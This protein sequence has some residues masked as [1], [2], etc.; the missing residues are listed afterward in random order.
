MRRLIVNADDFGLTTGI[1][2][3][4][5]QTHASGVVTSTTLMANGP[6]CDDAVRSAKNHPRLSVGCHIVLV[7]GIP[8]LKASDVRT[9]VE[10]RDADPPCFRKSPGSF[11]F[12]ALAG[13]LD[14]QQIEAE[15]TAQIRMLQG[16]GIVVTHLDTHKHTH[17]FPAVLRPLLRAAKACGIDALRNPFGPRLPFSVR[18]LRLRPRLW[19]RYFEVRVLSGFSSSFR[20]MVRE[21][22]MR[23]PDGT[24]G[25]AATGALDLELFGRIVD[26]IPEGTWEFVCHPGYHD[27]DLARVRT[28]LRESREKELEILTSAEARERLQRRGIQLIAYREL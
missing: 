9:L 7:D 1:N 26:L 28:R 22:G 19:K 10:A 21:Q 5:V 25:V 15:I 14:I 27:A 23:T 2:R 18:E 12:R 13:R 8:T 3:A 20:G 6:A 17:I 16:K 4:I 24:L 11:A